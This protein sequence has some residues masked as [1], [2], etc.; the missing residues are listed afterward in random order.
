MNNN[1]YVF[2]GTLI[3]IISI[4]ISFFS[5]KFKQIEK[6]NIVLN[7]KIKYLENSIE[8]NI[9]NFA[10]SYE[11]ENIKEM[12]IEEVNKIYD[13]DVD[14]IRNLGAISK[15]LLTGKNYHKHNSANPDASGT[16]VIPANVIIEGT[17]SVGN[18]P[19]IKGSKD[20]HSYEIGPG[21]NQCIK[22]HTPPKGKTRLIIRNETGQPG[23]QLVLIGEAGRGT[24]KPSV[25]HKDDKGLHISGNSDN[26][27]TGGLEIDVYENIIIKK[28]LVAKVLRTAVYV[29]GRDDNPEKG[30]LKILAS[31]VA[32][33]SNYSFMDYFRIFIKHNGGE[34]RI[35][36]G[37]AGVMTIDTSRDNAAGGDRIAFGGKVEA[38]WN[39]EGKQWEPTSYRTPA[40]EIFTRVG[41]RKFANGEAVENNVVLLDNTAL[42]RPYLHMNAEDVDGWLNTAIRGT[43]TQRKRFDHGLWSMCDDSECEAKPH[44]ANGTVVAIGGPSSE[45]KGIVWKDH[46]NKHGW[47]KIDGDSY[48]SFD[49]FD[50][51]SY[52][53]MKAA[54]N[55]N[56]K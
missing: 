5:S 23:A 4:L 24:E 11:K 38:K 25:L 9:E 7:K 12:I 49:F 32:F 36:S 55:K 10:D 22:I 17:L 53:K 48:G 30:P 39:D 40:L 43:E 41:T 42:R 35:Y 31:S 54:L 14:S 13:I 3:V 56:I 19:I 45:Y 16:L 50:D 37:L 47:Y 46:L 20:D 15:S 1:I 34:F 6:N 29:H 27:N 44:D 26:P 52:K 51:D 18:G 2:L 33:G 28:D 21:P 8:N